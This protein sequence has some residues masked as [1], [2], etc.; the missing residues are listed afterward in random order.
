MREV[1][2][3][4]AVSA[5]VFVVSAGEHVTGLTNVP[6]FTG[7]ASKNGAA[8][9]AVTMTAT[10]ELGKGWYRFVL[11]SG[12]TDTVGD[13][14]FT[15]SAASADPID[16]KYVVVPFANERFGYL[17]VSASSRFAATGT[18][19]SVASATATYI[20]DATFLGAQGLT[21]TYIQASAA[22]TYASALPT[23]AGDIIK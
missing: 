18:V 11:N 2:Q 23:T 17:D 9:A 16:F 20:S 13:L 3:S 6:S 19:A 21:A 1:L 8:F 4:N 10:A 22:Y 7:S 14:A 5:A 12:W 15:F